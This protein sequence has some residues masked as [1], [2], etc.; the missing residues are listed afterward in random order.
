MSTEI[1]NNEEYFRMIERRN[2]VQETNCVRP[3]CDRDRKERLDHL[4]KIIA[5]YEAKNIPIQGVNPDMFVGGR[6]GEVAKEMLR[7]AEEREYREEILGNEQEVNQEQ[8][9]D[10][11]VGVMEMLIASKTEKL[12]SKVS[13]CAQAYNSYLIGNGCPQHLN[14]NDPLKGIMAQVDRIFERFGNE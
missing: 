5:E 3:E 4:N 6:D 13:V 2:S 8:P 1:S 12:P 10:P 7:K 14:L 9:P 11:F